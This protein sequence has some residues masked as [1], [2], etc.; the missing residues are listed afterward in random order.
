MTR[1]ITVNEAEKC[2]MA[3]ITRSKALYQANFTL[4]Q[5][6]SYPKATAAAKRWVRQTLPDLP[7]PNTV[8]DLKT[9]RNTSGVVGVR[10][11]DA[12]RNRGGIVYP[13]WR[14]VAF[15]SGCPNTGGVGWSV[16]RYGDDKAFLCACLARQLESVDRAGIEAAWSDLKGT[17]ELRAM[18]KLKKL[19]PPPA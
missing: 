6:G 8:R 13:D 15:W 11:A 9:S 14:W 7:E 10:L 4:K 2:V 1:Y 17:R 3:R 5:F 16:K 18:L 12:T 19:A